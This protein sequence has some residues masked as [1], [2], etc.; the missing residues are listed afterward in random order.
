RMH[1]YLA[2]REAEAAWPGSRAILLDQDGHIGEGSTAN[3]VAFF[4]ERGLVT[5]R[6]TKVLP[7]VSQQALFEL[8]APLGIAQ[9]EADL[10]PAELAR[11]DEIFFTSTSSC[12][13]PVTQLDR[14]PVGTG[15]PG[16]VFRQLLTAW[17]RQV[18]VDIADQARQFADRE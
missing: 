17:S 18:G 8:A 13:L 9:S 5:P 6:R 7:G 4:A 14:R 1:Y 15:K 12:L 16:K 10:L 2:E 11:A 3:V